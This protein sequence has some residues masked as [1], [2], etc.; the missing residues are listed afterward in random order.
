VGLA[1]APGGHRQP[2]PVNSIVVE[3]PPEAVFEV[4][5]HGERYAEW[6]LGPSRSW[7]IDARWPA[8]GSMLE[9]R[10]G[11]PPL[12]L[13][14]TTSVVSSDPPRRMLLEARVRPLLVATVE[15]TIAPHAAGCLVRMEE[16]LVG[17]I[18]RGLPRWITEPLMR[19]RNDASLRRLRLLVLRSE[20]VP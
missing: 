14:D 4:L 12:A 7:P 10:S 16:R 13:R 5:S 1:D 17:G 15:L 11:I 6:V 20:G 18:A 3:A 2:M 9:H 19:R 8:P